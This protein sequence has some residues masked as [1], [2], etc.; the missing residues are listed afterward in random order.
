MRPAFCRLKIVHPGRRGEP[1][2]TLWLGEHE[3]LTCYPSPM[4]V[5]NQWTEGIRYRGRRNKMT[6]PVRELEEAMAT[7]TEKP[8]RMGGLRRLGAD[9]GVFIVYADTQAATQRASTPMQ[10]LEGLNGKAEKDIQVHKQ[11]HTWLFD[12]ILY[13]IRQLMG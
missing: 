5:W 9:L 2:W 12:L 1:Q 7:T 3:A 8:W 4:K 11:T 6:V 10:A 13:L